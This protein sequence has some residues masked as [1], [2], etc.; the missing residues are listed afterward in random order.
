MTRRRGGAHLAAAVVAGVLATGG[1]A[2]AMTGSRTGTVQDAVPASA[3]PVDLDAPPGQGATVTPAPEPGQA[4]TVAPPAGRATSPAPGNAEGGGA[5]PLERVTG[6]TPWSASVAS[7]SVPDLD[8]FVV[9]GLSREATPEQVDEAYRRR[10]ALAA[11]AVEAA[12]SEDDRGRV[13]QQQRM[14]AQAH[15][16]AAAL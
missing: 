16:L 13:E 4:G 3:A 1:V 8:P 7:V 12:S 6:R 11:E 10:A 14:L 15:E 9:L 5:A 2:T